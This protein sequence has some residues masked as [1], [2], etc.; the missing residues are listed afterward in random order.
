MLAFS[1]AECAS[2]VPLPPAKS[3]ET[4]NGLW[5]I[6]GCP[7]IHELGPGFLVGGGLFNT[8]ARRIALGWLESKRTA[9]VSRG[10]RFA[11]T[12]RMGL[13]CCPIKFSENDCVPVP[14]G[15]SSPAVA[16]IELP[17]S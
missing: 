1:I 10:E 9:C 5:P 15:G 8:Q 11:L 16:S 7:T 12:F 2:S 17:K 13:E 3:S 14:A 4:R 6:S